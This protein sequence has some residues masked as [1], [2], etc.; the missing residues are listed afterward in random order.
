MEALASGLPVVATSV[1]SVAEIVKDGL[2]GCLI[3]PGDIEA[4][5]LRLATLIDNPGLGKKMALYGKMDVAERFSIKKLNSRL[6]R[7]YETLL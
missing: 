6:V 2:S 1:G 3:P 7:I 4:M 5:S